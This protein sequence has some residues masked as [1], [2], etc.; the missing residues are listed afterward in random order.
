MDKQVTA[1][2][3]LMRL[4]ERYPESLAFKA[5]TDT[6]ISAEQRLLELKLERLG[7]Q[8]RELLDMR[9]QYY[10]APGKK[11]VLPKPMQV[12]E[13][14]RLREERFDMIAQASEH[15]MPAPVIPRMNLVQEE[16]LA[17]GDKMAD[18]ASTSEMLLEFF[19]Q[20]IK[21]VQQKRFM[22]LSRWAKCGT[23]GNSLERMSPELI[24]I[25]DTCVAEFEILHKAVD[26]IRAYR[27]QHI[28]RVLPED[29]A[30]KL[31]QWPCSPAAARLYTRWVTYNGRALRR[32]NKYFTAVAWLPYSK[33]FDLVR[34][35]K[36]LM[37]NNLSAVMSSSSTPTQL[38]TMVTTVDRLS[39]VLEQLRGQFQVEAD[40]AE[41]D[42]QRFLY[43]VNKMAQGMHALQ[44][45]D[46]VLPSYGSSLVEKIRTVEVVPPDT[47]SQGKTGAP[48]AI[49]PPVVAA[50]AFETTYLKESSWIDSIDVEPRIDPDQIQQRARLEANKKL[51]HILKV[52]LTFIDEDDPTVVARRL[53]EQVASHSDRS[54]PHGEG[55]VGGTVPYN[56]GGPT[57]AVVKPGV[58][59]KS[60][61]QLPAD[62]VTPYYW[63]RL[64]RIRQ[65]K[66]RLL[67]ILNYFRSVERRL[68]IDS[69][70]FA[71]N[72]AFAPPPDEDL[73]LDPKQERRGR[74]GPAA[75]SMLPEKSNKGLS[76]RGPTVD[77]IREGGR[78][79]EHDVYTQP[80]DYALDPDIV[81]TL[82]GVERRDD[83]YTVEDDGV[84]RVRDSEGM[85]VLYDAAQSDLAALDQEM[86]L[87]GSHYI[88][89]YNERHVPD[90]VTLLEDLY[91]S[92]ATFHD[93]KRVVVDAYVV[94][95][96]HTLDPD[97]RKALHQRIVDVIAK[98]PCL[99]LNG[100]YPCESYS[101]EI[102]ALQLEDRLL[103]DV[104]K[105]TI[106]DER[107]YRNFIHSRVH[108]SAE[109]IG[110]PEALYE[111]PAM[112]HANIGG[113]PGMTAGGLPN[114]RDRGAAPTNGLP[115]IVC[116]VTQEHYAPL[117]VFLSLGRA[118]SIG[119]LV[120]SVV[121]ELCAFHHLAGPV[122]IS[123]LRIAVLQQCIVEWRLL[124]ESD[125]MLSD[126]QHAAT[127]V[128]RA[129]SSGNRSTETTAPPP[130]A[131]D[132]QLGDDP[133][134]LDLMLQD[135]CKEMNKTAGQLRVQATKKSE[136]AETPLH[137]SQGELNLYLNTWSVMYVRKQLL[138]LVNET[139]V[140]QG[141]YKAQAEKF[142]EDPGPPLAPLGFDGEPR[143]A[144]AK[145]DPLCLDIV[146]RL[147]IAEIDPNLIQLDFNSVT[148]LRQILNFPPDDM[149]IALRFQ[150]VERSLYAVVVQWNQIL[151]DISER[152][153]N[154]AEEVALG[155]RT[156]D[157]ST[158]ALTQVPASKLLGA[159]AGAD[160]AA[161]KRLKA[162]QEGERVQQEVLARIGTR[163]LSVS[164]L[165]KPRREGLL[166]NFNQRML[167]SSKGSHGQG[168]GVAQVKKGREIKRELLNPYISQIM[169]DMTVQSLQVDVVQLVDKVTHLSYM[170]PKRTNVFTT[171]VD[172]AN[173][174][175]FLGPSEGEDGEAQNRTFLD[176]GQLG[177]IWHLPTAIEVIEELPTDYG[178]LQQYLRA[179][180]G[181]LDSMCILRATAT[182]ALSPADSLKPHACAEQLQQ[183]LLKIKTNV[184]GLPIKARRDVVQVADFMIGA[185]SRYFLRLQ[186]GL[187]GA[188]VRS[189][190]SDP[191][192]PTGTLR[193][194]L[195]N[196]DYRIGNKHDTAPPIMYTW[197][198]LHPKQKIH[199]RGPLLLSDQGCSYDRLCDALL[200][201]SPAH[202]ASVLSEASKAELLGEETL[203]QNHVSESHSPQ[204]AQALVVSVLETSASLETLK[205][206][207]C[208][209]VLGIPYLRNAAEHQRWLQVWESRI[210]SR[211]LEAKDKADKEQQA[212][213]S[214]T[215][216][217]GDRDKGYQERQLEKGNF[218]NT[219]LLVKAFLVNAVKEEL[220][221]MFLTVTTQNLT[222]HYGNLLEEVN[223]MGSGGP[224]RAQ[225]IASQAAGGPK[226][227]DAKAR[228][229]QSVRVPGLEAIKVDILSEFVSDLRD[230][231]QVKRQ[232]DGSS[233]LLV[234]QDTFNRS[235]D[236][237]ARKLR[238]WGAA[239]IAERLGTLT[240]HNNHLRHVLHIQERNAVYISGLRELD[241]RSMDRRIDAAVTDQCYTLL[242]RI[243]SLNKQLAESGK[244]LQTMEATVRDK[245][246]KEFEEL[247]RELGMQL[248]RIKSQ[249]KEYRDAL[250]TDMKG[251]L[252][253]IRKD[254]L[255]KM[256]HSTTA[257][258]ELKK[259]T[260]NMAEQEDKIEE[261]TT[262][263]A[264]LKRALLKLRTWNQMKDVNQKATF[265]KQ[266]TKVELEKQHAN[267]EL[268]LSR[269]EV[270]QKMAML[271]KQLS[272]TQSSLLAAEIERDKLRKEL[273]L[274]VR[275]KQTLLQWKVAKAM[276]LEELEMKVRK[277]ER[278]SHIDVDK[279]LIE[280]ERKDTE[281]KQI[282]TTNTEAVRRH[283]QLVET[284]ASKDIKRLRA[285]IL[286]EQ[287]MKN[288]A[289]QKLEAVRN[290]FRWEEYF[291]ATEDSEGMQNYWKRR[292]HDVNK[293]LQ[294]AMEENDRLWTV[295]RD[296]GVEL[297]QQV[298]GWLGERKEPPS[299]SVG[300]GGAF[301]GGGSGGGEQWRPVSAPGGPTLAGD[302]DSPSVGA[303]GGRA[304]AARGGARSSLS[305]Q[306]NRRTNK[307]AGAQSRPSSTLDKLPARPATM[308][309][310]N[311]FR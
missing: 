35:A 198:P 172:L 197:Y 99:D 96:E 26:E 75:G 39:T 281:L 295:A 229:L 73:N 29:L 58:V 101:A 140:L 297:P 143:M 265:D 300:P 310:G 148:G 6:R 291:E 247:V 280:L 277:F 199:F 11:L 257:P 241:N 233:G 242:F 64:L 260:R 259:V 47:G 269:D 24:K 28:P 119:Q 268:Y 218:L 283:Q 123:S 118:A 127:V 128:G 48:A 296:F 105:C 49:A 79:V 225:E 272:E 22:A 82:E 136:E 68:T 150:V 213:D 72:A 202:R 162:R 306:G 227:A 121:S 290:D 155:I 67:S 137:L 88:A 81:M 196:M 76:H 284:K 184:S 234:P 185:R 25:L 270:E 163:W 226:G 251:N 120:D 308:G 298:E 182:L 205:I 255:M 195:H 206:A 263:N 258:E 231:W 154:V 230:S 7:Q 86:L 13:I 4:H 66:R 57:E 180:T 77:S 177:N 126:A 145:P 190:T 74:H 287:R 286:H 125:A 244:A 288:E 252:H 201:I 304:G 135:L 133:F 243:D 250:H 237:L 152:D 161:E 216:A 289:F 173:A 262:E 278:W 294:A 253:E 38:P 65:S 94:A 299:H 89:A 44:G 109:M 93:A 103:R 98:R 51:D 167:A 157:T 52:E 116:P 214:A 170:L 246:R 32:L 111:T 31:P 292:Y 69:R 100:S 276:L 193:A 232:K 36:S 305:A 50:G 132:T 70:G 144:I 256:V 78:P 153:G 189:L 208:K 20:R 267:K 141:I 3:T 92:E 27:H 91:D 203:T 54:L 18:Y 2:Q 149:R 107:A 71:F 104:L 19:E 215:L 271:H 159:G 211:L 41:E 129:A 106:Q 239:Q 131:V 33:R 85:L 160:G 228:Q 110:F 122:L 87:L 266:L 210:N 164:A 124:V 311:K 293:N 139:E 236:T 113:V 249:F 181:L 217:M 245:V 90:R 56:L 134:A 114:G 63:L 194:L 179:I 40:L 42:G 43:Q 165:K 204:E 45:A 80:S 61:V 53:T 8:C 142:C 34:K 97:I 222:R 147:A 285:Q 187:H 221:Q 158:F 59:G 55:E 117:D 5:I 102:V 307:S 191:P 220:S 130:W 209:Q 274:A 1:H 178:L 46:K 60:S 17:A 115:P 14:L 301:G 146:P 192:G 279:L 303:A 151:V 273:E 108:E 235:V 200:R 282:Q 84:V 186:L 188:I 176:T 240:I 10:S 16:L 168:S 264:Q 23:K 219:E 224:A 37:L 169:S 212:I 238:D 12:P 254:A 183:E 302:L 112:G 309:G 62:K 248:N 138:D 83:D 15:K 261:L 275:N 156:S 174:S 171:T 223:Y 175:A 95:Y 30:S 207:L 9:L 21:W 166:A